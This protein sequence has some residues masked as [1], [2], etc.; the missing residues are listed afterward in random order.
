MAPAHVIISRQAIDSVCQM[1]FVLGGLWCLG[2]HLRKPDPR[3]AL[4][5]GA[6]LGCGIYAYVTSILFMPFYLALFWFIGWRAG[7]LDRR[8]M[9]WSIAGFVVAVL[10]MACGWRSTRR[11]RA[12]CNCNTTAPIPVR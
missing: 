3:L 8:T 9:A 5:A 12:A 10:P 2:A 11:P 6:I 7:V 1:P 4:A